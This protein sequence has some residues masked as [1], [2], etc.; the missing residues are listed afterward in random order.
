MSASEISAVALGMLAALAWGSGDFIGGLLSRRVSAFVVVFAVDVVG[1]IGLSA[2][3]VMIAEPLPTGPD[4]VFS[5]AAGVIGAVAITIFYRGLALYPMGLMAPLTALLTGLVPV[6]FGMALEGFP[7]PVTLA[8]MGLALVATWLITGSNGGLRML[9]QSGRQSLVYPAAAG[10]GFGLFF[11][12]F[13][14][15]SAGAVF[16][17][18]AAARLA[19]VIL[20][21]L[22]LALRARNSRTSLKNLPGSLLGILFLGGIFD[23]G[24]NVFFVLAAQAGRLDISSVLASL[25]PAATVT[26]AWIFLKE[27]LDRRQ[28]VGVAAALGAVVLI[29]L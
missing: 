19:A 13:D 5:A 23:A 22:I 17:P 7:R 11:V 10:L 29:S 2:S 27:N 12:L 20:I 24:G 1:L 26:L 15:I 25:F 3:A 28:L 21:G 4:L 8:G 18:I 16:W 9:S 6:L 14:Q